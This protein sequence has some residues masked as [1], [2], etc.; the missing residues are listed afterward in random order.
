M[1]K[2][3]AR[4]GW[5]QD[6]GLELTPDCISIRCPGSPG[7][8]APQHAAV[9][10]DGVVRA[11]LNR[12]DDGFVWDWPHDVFG[13]LL[14][15]VAV[16]TGA[17]LLGGPVPL[18][19]YRRLRWDDYRREGDAIIGRFAL[20]GPAAPQAAL[21]I[22]IE[23]CA[24]GARYGQGFARAQGGL[25]PFRVRLERLPPDGGD[26]AI[27]PRIGPTTFP[28]TVI[29]PPDAFAH[30]GF[31]EQAEPWRARG[32]VTARDAAERVHVELWIDGR[33]Q[34]ETVAD[35]PREDVAARGH[36]DGNSGFEIA[37]PASVQ[38]DR[39]LLIDVRVAPNGPSL[40][41]SPYLQ[42]PAPPYLGFFDGVDGGWAAGWIIG[43]AEPGRPIRA[44]AVCGGEVIGA[45]VA[46][47]HRGDV[48]EA[49]LP[50]SRCGFHFPLAAP[51][52]RLLGR[53]IVVRV[54]GTDH[55]LR[56]SPRQVTVNPN[57]A[58]F[59]ERDAR[60]PPRVRRRLAKTL[61]NRAGGLLIS[62]VMPVHN[63][64]RAWLISALGSVLAQ[65]SDNWELIC[66]DDGSTAPHVGE[67]LAA[68]A[69]ADARVRALRSPINLG[70][71]HAVNVGL[72]AAR[73]DFVTFMDHDD[74]LEPDAVHHLT[75]AAHATGADLLYSDEA[76]TG[77]DLDDIVEIRARPAFSHDYYLSHP[78]FVHLVAVRASLARALCGYDESLP[79]SADVDFVLRAIE[80]AGA[81]AHIPRVLYRWRTH[82]GSAGHARQ[83]EVMQATCGAIARHLARLRPEAQVRQ[84]GSF[85]QFRVDWPDDGGEVLIVVPTRDRVELLR[86]CIGSIERTSAA[87]NYR[88]V[89]IDHRS[90]DPETVGFLAELR[91]R[92]EV[93][94]YRGAFNFARMNNEAVRRHGRSAQHVLF[95]NNDV[96]AIAPGWLG[97]LRSLA[98]RPEIG[99]VGPLLLYPTN[100]VQHAGVIVGFGGAADHALRLVDA[101][102][103]EAT[104]SQGARKHGA[105]NPGYNCA[106][107]STRD[108]SAVTAACMMMRRD[109]FAR[110]GGFDER[111]AIGFNDTDLC[112]RL[113]AAGLKVLY[114]GQTMLYHHESA[115]RSVNDILAHP[116]DDVLLRRRWARYLTEGD[117][118]YSPLLTQSGVDHLLRADRG[119]KGRL[120]PRTVATTPV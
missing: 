51:A 63:P 119:C 100:R 42:P 3:R 23:L 14:D 31:V 66:V 90:D 1:P 73:G 21:P 52:N 49:G 86:S 117:P 13:R 58:R 45:G 99:A 40:G 46:D 9:L 80:R 33:K 85:N 113:R 7:G 94:P 28:P 79:I 110:F 91:R 62:I 60:V 112:L 108:Y 2:P 96:E 24:N 109:V 50:R 41:N 27:Q 71:A 103:P 104:S 89:V 78:Y 75:Q 101:F 111:F 118:F 16:E 15:I 47:Q 83:N 19:P 22:A 55:I 76:L 44:E 107:T 69:R 67:V 64:H 95:L 61:S 88:I 54:A 30:V 70:I 12:D 97:R 5:Q 81:V 18:Q 77:E 26:L 84:G 116:K 53:D 120:Q 82:E 10:V 59:L 74:A 93:M 65:W 68:S 114:D 72:R 29:V 98:A 106:L 25:Y 8:P 87:E 6:V 56:G 20:E 35:L 115:S 39:S 36:G 105:R 57:I 37:F 48:A 17:S 4:V 32:W 43:V 38:L 34:T 92:H 11:V 102:A